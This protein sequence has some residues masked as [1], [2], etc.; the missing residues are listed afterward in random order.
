MGENTDLPFFSLSFFLKQ[1]GPLPHWADHTNELKVTV[2]L[3]NVLIFILSLIVAFV[4]GPAL[5]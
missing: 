2:I 3:V 5:L 1:L 4:V